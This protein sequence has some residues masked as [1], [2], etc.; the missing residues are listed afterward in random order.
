MLRNGES[1][2][3]VGTFQGHKGAVWSCVL[4]DPALLA[5]TASADFSARVWNAVTGDEL[6]KFDHKHVVR[7]VAFSHGSS[8]AQL[9]TGGL[10]KLVRLYD[11][12]RPDAEPTTVGPAVDSLRSLLFLS[13]N[14]LLLA[15]YVDNPN[16]D[17][18]DLRTQQVVRTVESSG[19]VTSVDV[20]PC[21]KYLVTADGTEVCVRSASSFDLVKSLPM[22]YPVESA[23]YCPERGKLVAGGADMW[24]HLY[25]F[26]TGEQVDCSKGHHGPVHCV[27]FA[28]GGATYASGSEDGTIRIC[29]L[30]QPDSREAAEAVQICQMLQQF[31]APPYQPLPLAGPPN[32]SVFEVAAR[33]QPQQHELAQAHPG[34]LQ[35]QLQQ[36]Q[37]QQ[38]HQTVQ[39]VAAAGPRQTIVSSGRQGALPMPSSAAAPAANAPMAGLQYMQYQPQQQ[40]T[41]QHFSTQGQAQTLPAVS[42]AA[43]GGMHG[44]LDG[45]FG[46]PGSHSLQQAGT[47]AA[48]GHAAPAVLAKDVAA[49]ARAARQR[50]R[51]EAAAAAAERAAAQA[52]A[53]AAAAAAAAAS[54]VSGRGGGMGSAAAAGRTGGLPSLPLASSALAQLGLVSGP[55]GLAGLPLMDRDDSGRVGGEGGSLGDNPDSADAGS[56]ERA[57]RRMIK[58][59]ES[60]ARS[61]ARRQEYTAA[62]EQQ[63]A[64]LREQNKDLRVQVVLAAAAPPDPHAGHLEGQLLRRTRTTPL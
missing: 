25:D 33:Q 52:A 24:V 23:S 14:A 61:R 17:V 18:F 12:E 41:Q 16:V 53:Q 32:S 46:Y 30:A 57:Q 11:L 48:T 42:L 38:L 15:A 56:E 54:A 45:G 49:A 1:G 19:A 44:R 35:T 40:Q 9:A 55:A 27:R 26:E 62:L 43:P 47:P 59:R 6:H 63:V 8:T 37:Q 36:Q 31:E 50:K 20:T 51:K 4:N 28:P 10:E 22:P 58:N 39:L 29:H 64:Q 5:A 34:I 13:G 60:A 3:W 7:S 2:D 21:G